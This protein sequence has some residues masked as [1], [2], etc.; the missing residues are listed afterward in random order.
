MPTSKKIT[1]KRLGII[2]GGGNLPNHL[3][4]QCKRMGIEPYIVIFDGQESSVDVSKLQHLCTN[5]GSAG[6]IMDFFKGFSV[7]DLVMIGSINRPSFSDLKPDLKGVKI[8]SRIGIKFLGDNK[9]LEILED[10]LKNEGFML[11]GIHD[12]CDDILAKNGVMGMHSPTQSD[13]ENISLG[14]CSSQELGR[15][16]S[17]QSVVV[18]QGV[19]LAVED[20]EGT[21]RLIERAGFLLKDGEKAILVKSRKPQQSKHLDLPT[22][23]KQTIEKAY[24]SGLS[25]IAVHADNVIIVDQNEVIKL[26]DNYDMFVYGFDV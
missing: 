25:G 15:L 2:A 26:A 10:E 6:K 11:H 19:V 14:I 3:I 23:G 1:I 13:L 8:L 9:L 21:D 12:F 7:K 22:I 24:K 4:S 18:Q 5:L 20:S 16:D 17:G